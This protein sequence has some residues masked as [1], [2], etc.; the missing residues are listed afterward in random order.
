M[1]VLNIQGQQVQVDDSF[2]KLSPEDQ[3]RTVDEIAGSLKGGQAQPQQPAQ[4]APTADATASD[5][6]RSLSSGVPVVGG[7]LNKLDAATNALIAPVLN[8]FYDDKNQLQGSTFGERYSNSLKELTDREAQFAQQHPVLD[9]AAKITGGVAGTAP[10]I[11][12]APAAFGVG[13]GSLL[14]NAARGAASGAGLSAADAATRGD[15]PLRAAEF[16]AGGG[17]AGPLIGKA[18]GSVV[19]NA[20]PRAG[21]TNALAEAAQRQGVQFPA[22]AASPNLITQRV[23]GALKEFPFIGD[24]IVDRSLKASSQMGDA[25][26]RTEQGYG[27]GSVLNAGE[28][29]KTGLTDWITGKSK[30]VM[31]RLYGAVDPLINPNVTRP[32]TATEQT[33]GKILSERLAAKMTDAGK[34]VDLVS[35]ALP[36]MSRGGLT[37]QGLKTLRTQI[38]S[39]LDGSILPEAGT[40]MPDLKRIYGALTEDLRN[41]VLDAGGQPALK[42]FNRANTINQIV[43]QRREALAKVVGTQAQAAPEQVIDRLVG[44]ASTSS[45]A[46]I[47]KLMLARKTIGGN[48]WGEVASAAI[49]RIGRDAEGKFSPERFLTAY[50]KLSENGKQLLFRSTGQNDL[51]DALEDIALMS[52]H[53]KRLQ[54]FGNPSGTAR[55]GSLLATATGAVMQPHIAIPTAIGGRIAA[56]VMARPIKP[57]T[58]RLARTNPQIASLLQ[59]AT[60]GGAIGS[61]AG[62]AVG[63]TPIQPAPALQ[64]ATP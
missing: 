43:S 8:R 30:D 24:P 52:S 49:S 34:A 32:L 50:G 16:G 54:S 48:N 7:T 23:G 19:G 53:A 40:S 11:A 15:D 47:N 38:G 10:L 46:D 26:R 13:G 62:G 57:S 59:Y 21:A 55:A 28:T 56:G 42:A 9:T 61:T 1:P 27:S 35:N 60:T 33:A 31:G 64:Q 4:P 2:L 37:Y 39:Y 14:A 3:N 45:R 20:A 63:R 12:A 58:L 25:L 41:T 22:V 17:I 18:V 5:V 6:V 36:A 51:A 44:M 29:A